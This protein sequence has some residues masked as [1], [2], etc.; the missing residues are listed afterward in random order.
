[1]IEDIKNIEQNLELNKQFPNQNLNSLGNVKQLKKFSFNVRE[2]ILRLSAAV[3]R[4]AIFGSQSRDL[5][6]SCRLGT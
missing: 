4:A 6:F 1:M 5:F 3:A 2:H